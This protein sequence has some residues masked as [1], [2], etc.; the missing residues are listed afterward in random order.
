MD[1]P[2]FFR[3]PPVDGRE[4]RTVNTIDAGH[5]R[6]EQRALIASAE[7]T[8]VVTRGWP[9][10]GPVRRVHRRFPYRITRT[11]QIVSGFTQPHSTTGGVRA[12]VQTHQRVPDQ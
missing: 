8:D 4:W 6:S 1:V 2:L 10:A 5:G 12:P 11:Q 7:R 3:D 9:G